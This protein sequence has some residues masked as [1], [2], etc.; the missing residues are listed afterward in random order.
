M[1]DE[2]KLRRN[3]ARCTKCGD[4]VESKHRHN[5]VSCQCGGMFVDGGLAY[6]RRGYGMGAGFEELS[7]YEGDEPN[8]AIITNV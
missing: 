5:L 7:E 8:G 3:R 6:L 1:A 2:R 4:I